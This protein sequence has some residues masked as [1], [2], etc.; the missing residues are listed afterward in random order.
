MPRKP[1]LI[2]C[3]ALLVLFALF[4]AFAAAGSAYKVN[5]RDLTDMSVQE[6]YELEDAIVDS[7]HVVFE[8]E[9]AASPKGK[10]VST[11]VANEESKKFH[12]PY[13][14]YAIQMGISR[15]FITAD[16]SDLVEQ[17]Y[18]PCG[19]CNPYPDQ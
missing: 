12:Y 6:L 5:G 18:S 10:T 19:R 7:L 2:A 3:A 4:A 9:L 16:P 8:R 13:C 14:Y 15:Q 17:G 11:Y 1:I